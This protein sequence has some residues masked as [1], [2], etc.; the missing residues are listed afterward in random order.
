MSK[1]VEFEGTQIQVPDNFEKFQCSN[2]GVKDGKYQCTGYDIITTDGRELVC[3]KYHEGKCIQYENQKTSNNIVFI[4]I[5]IT[6]A[7][8]IIILLL[9]LIFKKKK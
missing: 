2:G 4:G 6:L 8:I 9:I 1:V 5:G 3:T 7:I